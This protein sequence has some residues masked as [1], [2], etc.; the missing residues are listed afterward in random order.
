MLLVVS[1]VPDT[2]NAIAVVLSVFISAQVNDPVNDPLSLRVHH[3][4]E[5]VTNN[6]VLL[7]AS[8]P[9]QGIKY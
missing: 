3:D 1:H 5:T 9:E 8:K 7:N 2:C 6:G 4:S